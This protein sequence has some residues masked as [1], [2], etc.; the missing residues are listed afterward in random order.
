MQ[1]GAWLALAMLW[2]MYFFTLVPFGEMSTFAMINGDAPPLPI[3]EELAK[4]IAPFGNW[5][6]LFH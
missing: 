6:C 4:Y 5:N 2:L 1:W 3:W